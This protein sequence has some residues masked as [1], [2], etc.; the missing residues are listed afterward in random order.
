MRTHRFL[1]PDP[2]TNSTGG[3]RITGAGEVDQDGY[4]FAGGTGLELPVE[5]GLAVYTIVLSFQLETLAPPTGD[6]FG[7]LID[8]RGGTSDSGLYVGPNGSLE[9]IPASG[10]A[11]LD[12]A[13]GTVELSPVHLV[14]TRDAG[15][16]VTLYVNGLQVGTLDDAAADF[17]IGTAV[18]FFQDDDMPA[19]AGPENPAGVCDS[20]TIHDRALSAA[21]VQL[22]EGLIALDLM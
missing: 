4:H 10:S 19:E 14:L 15:E 11:E 20:I 17:E 2:F 21:E 18:R 1:F 6:G 16:L 12:A 8:W 9:L 13:P 22:L 7:K 3:A 5:A